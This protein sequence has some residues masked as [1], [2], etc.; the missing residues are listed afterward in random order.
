[1]LKNQDPKQ[2][3]FKLIC[4]NIAEVKQSVTNNALKICIISLVK[5]MPFM[6]EKSHCGIRYLVLNILFKFHFNSFFFQVI[7]M[8]RLCFFNPR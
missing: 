8:S 3:L 6:I 4:F 2:E 1:M 7:S 5:N